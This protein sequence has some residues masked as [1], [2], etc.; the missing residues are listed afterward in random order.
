MY[1]DDPFFTVAYGGNSVSL[2]FSSDASIST[3]ALPTYPKGAWSA[4]AFVHPNRH[5]QY[6]QHSGGGL[7]PDTVLGLIRRC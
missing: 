5:L 2:E 6:W 4:D 3:F 7:T 1:V